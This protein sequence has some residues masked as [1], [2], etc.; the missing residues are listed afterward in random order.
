VLS[1]PSVHAADGCVMAAGFFAPLHR[2]SFPDQGPPRIEEPHARLCLENM[3][4][5]I[6]GDH[7]P[8]D[9]DNLSAAC[10]PCVP[11]LNLSTPTQAD[12]KAHMKEKA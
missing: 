4:R 5:H 1:C 12:I 3:T 9:P 8:S 2:G 7:P 11:V 10:G 6:L